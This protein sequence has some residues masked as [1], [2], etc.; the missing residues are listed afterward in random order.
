VEIGSNRT[1]IPIR[2]ISEAL[3]AEVKWVSEDK[4]VIINDGG[5]QITLTLGSLEVMVDGQ[6]VTIDCAPVVVNPGRTFVPLR[7]ISE[8]LGAT[9]DYQEDKQIVIER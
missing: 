4:Q 9:V 3:G 6:P 5:K 7:F 1:L 8:T 2:F